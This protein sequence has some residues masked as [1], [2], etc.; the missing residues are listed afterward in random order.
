MKTILESY[1]IK[2]L[3]DFIRTHNK[4]VRKQTSEKIKEIRKNINKKRI[5]DIKG[6]KK[7]LIKMKLF[8]EC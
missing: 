6:L 3:K 4:D 5:I 8:L 1:S 2:E 7:K